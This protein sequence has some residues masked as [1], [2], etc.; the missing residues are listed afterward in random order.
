MLDLGIIENSSSP[1]SS[2]MVGIEKKNGD[3]RICLDA[4]KINTRI[5]PD[6]ERPMNID[7]IMNKFRGTKYLSS[8]DLT[9]GYWQCSLRRS[10][11]KS[12]H[13]YTRDGTISTKCYHLD[14]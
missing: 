7:N 6:R 13:F 5:I 4:R 11:E 2:P 12:R 10:A 1:W 9:A 14:W 3:F 8:I